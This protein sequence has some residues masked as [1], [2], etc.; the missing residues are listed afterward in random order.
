[1]TATLRERLGCWLHERWRAE[2]VLRMPR[3]AA[4]LGWSWLDLCNRNQRLRKD[5]HTPGRVCAWSDSSKLTVARV[6]PDIGAR[7]LR[8]VLK[9][10]PVRFAPDAEPSICAEPEVSIL[11]PIA[12]TERIAQFRL[13]LA[14]AR[15]QVGV[16]VE[17]VVVEQ[18]PEPTLRG[19]LPEGVRYLHQPVASGTE[20]NK[21][22]AL[23]AAASCASGRYLIIL[24]ADLLIP[25]RFASE[26]AKALGELES[27]RP[28]R[29]IFYL[30]R[31]SSNHVSSAG[32]LSSSLAADS[33]ITNTPMPIALRRS[34]YWEL[35]GHDETY[36]G[37]GGEDSEFL[38]R[39]RTRTI[40]EGGWMPVLH[41]WHPPAAKKAD[42][43]RNRELHDAKMAMAAVERIRMLRRPKP[44]PVKS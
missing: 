1:M 3:L 15:A 26:C 20:F 36:A 25:Q 5:L 30:D 23:N 6:F 10:W 35:G 33:V 7:L 37:W 24:D 22:R 12:G 40:G 38:D 28:T 17:I 13:A 11:M 42:G 41:A 29:L 9:E 39:L 32:D 44:E 31:P 18:W 21:S 16:A 34:T 43:T 8:H 14:A 19:T 2:L 27:A 4:L